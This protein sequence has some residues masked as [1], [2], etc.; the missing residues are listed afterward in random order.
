MRI[1]VEELPEAGLELAFGPTDR[2]AVDAARQGLDGEVLELAG[3]LRVRRLG[4]GVQVTGRARAAVAQRCVRCLREV[5][6]VVDGPVSLWY[7]ASPEHAPDQAA[8]TADA[9]DVGFLEGGDLDLGVVLMEFFALEGP[10]VVRCADPL[11]EV[12]EEGPCELATVDPEPAMDPR[13]AI[14]KDLDLDG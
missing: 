6:V 12:L 11:V 5:R 1:V 9:L 13:F 2:W 7:E 8:L 10:T 3:T 14:L 4:P